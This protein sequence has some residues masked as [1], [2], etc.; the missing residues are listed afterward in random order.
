MSFTVETF[1]ALALKTP[2]PPPP[3]HTGTRVATGG[4]ILVQDR[5]VKEVKVPPH[6]THTGLNTVS[7]LAPRQYELKDV[8]VTQK[9]CINRP[10]TC[11]SLRQARHIC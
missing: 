4:E 2:P 1:K 3:H 8:T 7:F 11:R 10:R 9:D 6:Q 5:E